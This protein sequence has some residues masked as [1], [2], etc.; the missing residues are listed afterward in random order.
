[1]VYNIYEKTFEGKW[2]HGMIG[3]V[4]NQTPVLSALHMT[5]NM[6]DVN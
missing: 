6:P 2:K 5:S 4:N 3:Q 1:M